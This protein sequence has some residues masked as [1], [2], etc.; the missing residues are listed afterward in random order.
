MEAARF[1]STSRSHQLQQVGTPSRRNGLL[2]RTGRMC[3]QSSARH[4]LH[5]SAVLSSPN[6]ISQRLGA[7]PNP[8][9]QTYPNWGTQTWGKLDI[10]LPCN[11][12][13]AISMRYV[14]MWVRPD[15]QE[16]V[17]ETDDISQCV[18]W[19]SRQTEN[20]AEFSEADYNVIDR[21]LDADIPRATSFL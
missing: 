8:I 13:G 7:N 18:L 12:T 20:S 21:D 14:L 6:D 11:Q 2:R 10:N 4:S 5:F 15:R 19:I 1:S 9:S 17:F 16:P 3:A